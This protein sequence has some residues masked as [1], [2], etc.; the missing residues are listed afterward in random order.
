MAELVAEGKVLHLGLSEASV[1]T[2]RRAS[3]VHP[4]AA[5]QSEWSI[6]TRDLEAEVLPTCRELGIAIIPYSPLGR[7]LL[8]S[9]VTSFDDLPEGDIRRSF[10]RFQPGAIEQNVKSLKVVDDI[11]A[12]HSA[13]PGQIALAWLLAKG[14]D[15]VSIPSTKRISRLEENLGAC[16]I[17]LTNDELAE[18]DGV[19]VVGARFYG[20]LAWLNRTTPSSS[21]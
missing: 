2:L 1:D 16:E 12:A 17:A 5:L 14:E 15:V 4:I 8:T 6:V 9:E 18:L 3:A 13:T 11:A 19:Q 10:P 21:P 20:D 7:G